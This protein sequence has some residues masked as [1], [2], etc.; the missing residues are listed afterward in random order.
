VQFSIKGSC[1]RKD[2]KMQLWQQALENS[3]ASPRSSASQLIESD[4]QCSRATATDFITKVKLTCAW[5]ETAYAQSITYSLRSCSEREP[6]LSQVRQNANRYA[7]C[8]RFR[9]LDLHLSLRACD[10]VRDKSSESFTHTCSAL[11]EAPDNHG[12]NLS[13]A[14]GPWLRI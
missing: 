14:D 5:K 12:S 2:L 7:S 3:S 10:S 13:A 1:S 9:V 6:G 8:E 11:A 4:T